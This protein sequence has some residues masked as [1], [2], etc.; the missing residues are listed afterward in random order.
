MEPVLHLKLPLQLFYS[1]RHW[2]CDW[3]PTVPNVTTFVF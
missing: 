3:L 1:S 2:V